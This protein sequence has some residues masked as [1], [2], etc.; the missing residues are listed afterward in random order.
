MATAIIPQSKIHGPRKF[1]CAGVVQLVEQRSANHVN[2]EAKAAREQIWTSHQTFQGWTC[3]QCEWNYPV[4]T[5]LNDP[6]ARTAYDRL[7]A[8][9]FRDHKCAD[10][11]SRLAPASHDSFT[12]RLRKL[13][14]SGFKPKDAVDLMLQEVTLEYRN[15][16]ATL[17][18]AKAEGEDFLRRVRAGLI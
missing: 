9:K 14:A 17:A 10:Q 15:Q 7:A 12:A 16:P 4:P 2:L 6:E 13:V 11:L 1:R 18:Q 8:A 3:S 5:L